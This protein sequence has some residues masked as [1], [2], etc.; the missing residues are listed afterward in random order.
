MGV[1]LIPQPINMM[2]PRL[3]ELLWA[4]QVNFNLLNKLNSEN[5]LTARHSI[6]KKITSLNASN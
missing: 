1:G 5:Y 2:R 6:N 3:H 4:I